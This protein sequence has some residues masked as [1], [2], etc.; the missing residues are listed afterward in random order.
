[1]KSLTNNINSHKNIFNN[2]QYSSLE[3]NLN[4][5]NFNN[6]NNNNN[7]YNT[8]TNTHVQFKNLILEKILPG[9][10]A[11]KSNIGSDFCEITK[12]NNTTTNNNNNNNNTATISNNNL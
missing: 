12:N 9:V 4:N 5:D 10:E 1:M 3:N 8:N 7:N 6:N 2:Y 11:G